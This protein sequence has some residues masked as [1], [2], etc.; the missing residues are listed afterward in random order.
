MNDKCTED[1]ESDIPTFFET[2]D[3]QTPGLEIRV[4]AQTSV[5]I[6]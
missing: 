1:S 6:V 5:G 2:F 3:A 4:H